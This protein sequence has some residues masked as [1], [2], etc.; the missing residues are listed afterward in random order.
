MD[1]FLRVQAEDPP[2]RTTDLVVTA[3]PQHS[4][5]TLTSELSRHLGLGQTREV[6]LF[7]HSTGERLDPGSTIRSCGI[8]S[9]EQLTLR[10]S[11]RR[12]SSPV[13]RSTGLRLAITSGPS[14]GYVHTLTPGFYTIGRNHKPGEFHIAVADP[15][16]GADQFKLEVGHDLSVIATEKPKPANK[17]TV[18]G[19]VCSSVFA[20]EPDDVIRAGATS[21][22]VKALGSS[23]ATIADALGNVPFHR[24]PRRPQYPRPVKLPAMGEIPT[25]PEAARLSPTAL[26]LPVLGGVLMAVMFREP[27]FLAFIL[28]AP[29]SALASYLDNRKDRAQRYKTAVDRFDHRLDN[30]RRGLDAALRDER[31]RRVASAPDTADLLVQAETRDKN[32]WCRSRD[33][34]DFL[35]L[36]VGVGDLP[37]L[38][39]TEDER[40]GDDDLRDAVRKVNDAAS[41]LP[42]VPVT[43]PFRDLGVVGIHGDHGAAESLTHSLLVQACCLH[44]PEDMVVAAAA[45]DS[46]QLIDWLKWVPHTRST[47]SPLA[48]PHLAR[49]KPDSDALIRELLD[50]AQFRASTDGRGLDRRWPWVLVVLDRL[51]EPDPSAVSQLLDLCPQVGIAVLWVSDSAV[52]VP[53]QARA[54]VECQKA[55]SGHQSQVWFTDPDME[56]HIL[57]LEG[58]HAGVPDSVGRALAPLRDASSSSMTAA[59][60]RIAP[61]LTALGVDAVTTAWLKEQWAKDRGYAVSTAIGLTADGPLRIDL[62]ENGPHALIGGTSGSGK[63]ELLQSLV[64]GLIAFQS[65]RDVTLLFIDFKGGSASEVFK[66]LPHIVGRVTDLD[67]TLALRAQTSIRAELRRRVA[68]F[69]AL[70]AKDLREMRAKFPSQAPPSLVLVID[71]FATLVKE[72]PDFV[73]GLVDIAQRGRSYGIHLILATQRPSAAVDDNILA[74]TNLRIALRM[75]DSAES[76]SVIGTPDAAEIPVPLKGR[77]LARLGPGQLIEFQSGFSGAPRRTGD[78]P[79]P[80][81]VVDFSG[82]ELQVAARRAEE[83]DGPSQLADLIGIVEGLQEPA[84][85]QIWNPLLP[86][87]LT[88][89]DVRLEDAGG[90]RARCVGRDVVVGKADDPVQQQQYPSVVDLESGGGL[91]V[92]GNAGSGKTTLLRSLAVSAA[93]DDSEATGSGLVL[94]VFDFSS[95]GLRDLERLP[96]CGGVAT[97]ADLEAATRLLSVLDRE[98]VRRGGSML[99]G[100]DDGPRQRVVVLVDGYSAL[101]EALAATSG[102]QEQTSD[103]WLQMFHRLAVE[104]RQVGVHFAIAAERAASV[105]TSLLAA[106]TTRVVMRQVDDAESRELGAPSTR[107]LPAGGCYVGGLRTQIAVLN[108][109]MLH[110]AAGLRGSVPTQLVTRKLPDD[111]ALP[112]GSHQ[113]Y[114]GRLGLADLSGEAVR[115]DLQSTSSN[116]FVFGPPQSGK[117]RAL[118]TIARELRHAGHDIFAVGPEDSGLRGVEGA[119]AGF[120]RDEALATLGDLKGRLAHPAAAK[121]CVLIFDDL[122]LMDH[123]E[124]Y[125]YFEAFLADRNL[126]LAGSASVTTGFY[127][128][129]LL[130]EVPKKW[131]QILFLQ[132]GSSREVAD[133]VGLTR[134][135]LLRLGLEMPAGRGV[136]VANRRSTVVQVA[137]R[138]ARPVG[139]AVDGKVG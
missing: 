25:R 38:V 115:F 65:P 52:R 3:D 55:D 44:S 57:D 137:N 109:P 84:A 11:T 81:R 96:Q 50:V 138:V 66:R 90:D 40:G 37:P 76:N 91:L 6:A 87:S 59:I 112:V 18:N 124:F 2:A 54:I 15:L 10:G 131:R 47:G 129:K 49:N 30:H 111:V 20:I 108:R 14:A 21:F 98:V 72:L 39:L 103:D 23:G 123:A 41:V 64:A 117:S 31:V 95:G 26:L 53:P 106:I 85:R 43:V 60:P 24:T 139:Q 28:I 45:G 86:I 32:L 118:A 99:P 89:D 29:L 104:G 68:D 36:R 114:R 80:L 17:A 34:P 13:R 48:G 33:H 134:L 61:L 67:E 135:P 19:E 22:S 107:N 82:G 128:N 71:E 1:L 63:S 113:M 62:V 93:L 119:S 83:A 136:F 133:F 9:G 73:A 35:A 4:V 69:A 126:R 102:N 92:F 121:K 122:D 8:L 116:L 27:R 110:V 79:E 78:G 12:A 75:L 94:F 88:L 7:R 101:V 127:S 97:S 105:R 16:F 5:A 46:L 74:N 58:V 130:Q 51:L 42:E 70:G 120:G 100:S 56:P 125:P 132:P 77:A